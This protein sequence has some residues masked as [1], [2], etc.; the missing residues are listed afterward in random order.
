MAY[1]IAAT[2]LG[3]VLLRLLYP[4]TKSSCCR[5]NRADLSA[6]LPQLLTSTA[7]KHP[8]NKKKEEN[9]QNFGAIS[10]KILGACH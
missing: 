4:R 7:M 6:Q 8:A 2:G 5:L 3:G 1:Y 9:N 10:D